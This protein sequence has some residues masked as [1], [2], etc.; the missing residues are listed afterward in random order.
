MVQKRSIDEINDDHRIDDRWTETKLYA[1]GY[2][3]RGDGKCKTCGET[4]EFWKREKA[5]DY[6][7]R[8][9]WQILEPVTLAVHH[10]PGK[11]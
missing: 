2:E 6:K 7:G 8:A 1:A 5:E 4:V 11:R 10:C 9:L 3:S